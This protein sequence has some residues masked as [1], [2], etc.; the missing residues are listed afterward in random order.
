MGSLISVIATI[1]FLYTIYDMLANQ[2]VAS[3]NPWAYPNFF[4][5]TPSFVKESQTTTTLEWALPSPTPF[6]AYNMMPVQS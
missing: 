2:P 1:V 4:M 5:S 3:S 6:H